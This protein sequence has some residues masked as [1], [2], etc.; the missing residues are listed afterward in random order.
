M[1][2]PAVRPTGS[3]DSRNRTRSVPSSITVSPSP[4]LKNSKSLQRPVPVPSSSIPHVSSPLLDPSRQR[5]RIGTGMIYKKSGPI[6]SEFGVASGLKRPVDNHRTWRCQGSTVRRAFPVEDRR[7][8]RRFFTVFERRVWHC[9]LRICLC[10]SI[11]LFPLDL[12]SVPSLAEFR[13]RFLR[14]FH[15]SLCRIRVYVPTSVR[16]SFFKPLFGFD[17]FMAPLLPFHVLL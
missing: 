9:P 15:D 5:S 11:K 12:G 17:V 16:L 2:N 14:S 3:L 7:Q 10:L 1:S 4:L 13:R 6:T 8:L